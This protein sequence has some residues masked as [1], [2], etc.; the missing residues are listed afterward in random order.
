MEPTISQTTIMLNKNQLAAAQ[1]A[2]LEHGVKQ[3]AKIISSEV[4]VGAFVDTKPGLGTL[5]TIR[6]VMPVIGTLNCFDEAD[7]GFLCDLDVLVPAAVG[8]KV[9]VF[10]VHDTKFK[11]TTDLSTRLERIARQGGR[12]VFVSKHRLNFGD[13]SDYLASRVFRDSFA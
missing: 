1:L 12:F 7:V 9:I 5:Y 3:L 11:I 8:N 13:I 4:A 6:Q 10:D 2:R